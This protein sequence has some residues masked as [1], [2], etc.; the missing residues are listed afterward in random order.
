MVAIHLG[1]QEGEP[2]LHGRQWAKTIDFTAFLQLPDPRNLCLYVQR[3]VKEA[4][5]DNFA[6]I[7]IFSDTVFE[8]W[9]RGEAGS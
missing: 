8:S 5:S 1:D 4:I 7:S 6:E 3:D 2:P 9:K